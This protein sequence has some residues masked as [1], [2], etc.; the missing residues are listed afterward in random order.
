[1]TFS[2]AIGMRSAQQRWETLPLRSFLLQSKET[3]RG[4]LPL[5]GV[6]LHPGVRLR[7]EGDGR[8]A[9]SEE[10]S[11]YKLVQP[12]DVVMNR[13]G[14]PHGSVGVSEWRGITSPAYWVMNV[15]RSIADPRFVHHLLRARH[16]IAEYERRGKYLP[17]NQFDISWDQFR[18]IEVRLP[19]LEEQRRIA[20]F[21]DV[22]ISRLGRI[23]HAQSHV[24]R[25]LS[26]RQTTAI[27]LRLD[28]LYQTSPT[29]PARRVID[30]VEQG[31]SPQC[32][33]TAAVGEE[34]GVLKV[35]CLRPGV[36]IE[37]ENKRVGDEYLPNRRHEVREGDVLITR[38]NTPDLVGSVAVVPAVRR[39]LLLSDK[40]FRVKL[41]PAIDREYFSLVAR[42]GQI[43][44]RSAAASNGASQS[45]ANL[46][47]E[48]VK[49]WPIP[50][51]SL[52]VQRQVVDEFADQARVIGSTLQTID[53]HLALLNERRQALVTAAV[54]GQIDVTAARG[55]GVS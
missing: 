17:P 32:D 43:R 1:M 41:S 55:V 31:S 47:F 49:A 8:P 29:V 53:R 23:A 6:S 15:V 21:L 10:L 52:D 33:T 37:G 13:L 25:L 34:W 27:D 16:M 7:Q 28:E 2:D 35:S 19:P 42:G 5:L 3:G 4:E 12:G 9:P 14:K 22:E 48:E 11:L 18:S 45:M 20:D 46:R 44:L 30:N 39:H 51:P 26:E 50:M 54:T 24:I 40:I 36:F 38:A